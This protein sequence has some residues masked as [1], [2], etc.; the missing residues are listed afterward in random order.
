MK[1]PSEEGR[2]VDGTVDE[3]ASVGVTPKDLVGAEVVH[4]ILVKE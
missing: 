3:E 4:D 2:Y 1:T